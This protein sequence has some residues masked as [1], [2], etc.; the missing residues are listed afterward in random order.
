MAIQ[1][2]TTATNGEIDLYEIADF[3]V[4]GWKTIALTTTI[5]T[6]LGVGV[7]LMLPV[8]YQ[9]SVAIEGGTV[10]TKDVEPV[11]VLAD[12]MR[13][14]S[15]YSTETLVKC[16]DG[17]D[18]NPAQSVVQMLGLNVP[19]D[20]TFVN[21]S[22]KLKTRDAARICL[23]AVLDDVRTNQKNLFNAIKSSSDKEL[24]HLK[25]ELVRNEQLKAEEIKL[26]QSQLDATQSELAK[27]REFLQNFQLQ[28]ESIDVKDEKFSASSLLV[29]IISEKEAEA[30]DLNDK[31]MEIESRIRLKSGHPDTEKNIS[32]LKLR[33]S[34]L[35]EQMRAPITREAQFAV[36]VYSLERRAEPR[37][38]IVTVGGLIAGGFFGILLLL[39]VHGARA[40]SERRA[41][42]Q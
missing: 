18:Q 8:K 36:P 7:S 2:Q 20:S 25:F 27:V 21:I 37:R 42:A 4:S 23:E 22:A 38:S 29:S 12:R 40:F 11:A 26:Y 24:E 16:Q 35:Q 33:I 1:D 5:G 14:P 30:L 39:F 17:A 9:A 3:I 28:K 19:R 34:L 41:R 6:I 10:A 31:I 13:S 15:F 32:D